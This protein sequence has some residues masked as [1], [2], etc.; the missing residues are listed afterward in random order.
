[1]VLLESSYHKLLLPVHGSITT[2]VV[3]PHRNGYALV[4]PRD[5]VTSLDYVALHQIVDLNDICNRTDQCFVRQCVHK[6]GHFL[7]NFDF[8]HVQLGKIG[9]LH[10]PATEIGQHHGRFR[11]LHL[12]QMHSHFRLRHGHLG[13]LNLLWRR[14]GQ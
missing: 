12:G 14:I 8:S 4:S 10:H 13:L 2:W 1:M 11:Y 3:I 6:H 7:P 9:S 5:I